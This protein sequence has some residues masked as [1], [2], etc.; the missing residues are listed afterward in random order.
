MSSHHHDRHHKS[1]SNKG[2]IVLDKQTIHD[3]LESAYDHAA[4]EGTTTTVIAN[5]SGMSMSIQPRK[6]KHKYPECRRCYH[7]RH[8][9][10]DG[11]CYDCYDHVRRR[12]L[13]A[14]SN[15]QYLEYPER[16]ALK[17]R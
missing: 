8:P 7:H 17:W 3:I 12:E 9:Y 5:A 10:A 14:A 11:Y 16:K 13:A 6:D 15:R 4:R 1:H 2:G